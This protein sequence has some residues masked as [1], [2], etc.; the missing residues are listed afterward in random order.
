MDSNTSGDPGQALADLGSTVVALATVG[1]FAVSV[2]L[3]VFKD[4]IADAAK[5]LIGA[6]K[7]NPSATAEAADVTL[8]QIVADMPED[9]KAKIAAK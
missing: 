2:S 6:V 1:T 7:G 8:D 9:I 5:K 3:A 4:Q